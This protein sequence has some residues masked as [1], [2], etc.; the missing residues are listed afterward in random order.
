[1]TT[2]SLLSALALLVAVALTPLDTSAQPSWD[3]Q[4]VFNSGPQFP[5][6]SF[7]DAG[8]AY[9]AGFALD[10]GYYYRADDALFIGFNGGYH[11]F[12]GKQGTANDRNLLPL[13][14]AL[15]YNFSLTGLQ[16]Y[17]GIE[18]GPVLVQNTNAANGTEV[19]MTPRLGLRIPLSRGVDLDLNVK[20]NVVFAEESSTYVGGNGGFAYILDRE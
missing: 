15:K 7:A 6:G 1:M 16:P 17:L 4:I 2:R 12:K 11:Q 14:L 5:T 8:D 19:G 3:H 10:L 9:K 20:Y 13:H 18:G